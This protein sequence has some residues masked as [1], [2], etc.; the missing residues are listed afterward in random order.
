MRKKFLISC[1]AILS[2]AGSL[3]AVLPSGK[4]IGKNV[5][6]F[7]PVNYDAK[8]HLPS[9]AL[10]IEPTVKGNVPDN[11]SV[12]PDFYL[13]D[14]LSVAAFPILKG[15]S[16]YGT[17]EAKGSLIRNDKKIKL[18][19]TDNYKYLKDDGLRLYQSHPWVLGVN[20]DGSAF[21]IV[22]V[23]PWKQLIDITDSI[24]FTL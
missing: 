24:R 15:T 1:L 21:G 16:L 2:I 10:L 8:S 4:L 14:S 17:G 23:N 9:F 13:K 5:S 3:F 6:V 22:A 19:N 20:S 7:Y 18:W 11:W 12:K